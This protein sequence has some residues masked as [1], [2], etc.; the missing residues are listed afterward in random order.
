MKSQKRIFT[1]ACI[2]LLFFAFALSCFAAPTSAIPAKRLQNRLVDSAALLDA[3]EEK[4][5]LFTLNEISARQ[6]CDIVIVT[7]D[8]LDGKTATEYADDFF[9]Y[10]GYGY[11]KTRDGILLLISMEARDWALSTHGYGIEAFTDAGQAYMM[12]D[13]VLPC[14]SDD[15]FYGAFT[16]F[17]AQCDAFLTQAANDE[18]YD[19]H[20]LPGS[21]EDVY[22]PTHEVELLLDDGEL[23]SAA[24]ESELR[25]QLKDISERH[26]CDVAIITMAALDG[27][28]P[29]DYATRLYDE[30]GY[31]SP[32]GYGGVLLMIDA[33]RKNATIIG[34]DRGTAVSQQIPTAFSSLL[35]EGRYAEACAEY[36]SYCDSSL[37][38]AA[39][40]GYPPSDSLF[41]SGYS[42]FFGFRRS[43]PVMLFLSLGAGLL[44]AFVVM[45]LVKQPLKSV[46]QQTNAHYYARSGSLYVTAAH[47]Q[48]LYRNVS[49]TAIPRHDDTQH[50]NHHSG[51]MH[52]GGASA[53]GSSTHVSSSGSTHGGSSGSF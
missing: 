36:I 28:E 14:L 29:F 51:G 6:E 32:N 27:I 3:L 16:E 18:P 53:G 31:G 19:S 49:R 2:A 40:E 43:L 37:T 21:W 47:E 41:I 1:A 50:H 25:A 20:N 33:Q 45:L 23:L 13:F 22:F 24:E 35:T 9:D 12:D 46:R 5:L 38:Q 8:A 34:R 48:Y 15:D 17:A 7:V 42:D 52:G 11:G 26:A 30:N 39:L 44:L 4:E 10:N